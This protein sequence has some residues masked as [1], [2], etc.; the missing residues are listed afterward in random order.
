MEKNWSICWYVRWRY[1]FTCFE[2]VSNE[3]QCFATVMQ[4]AVMQLCV[5]HKCKR[6]LGVGVLGSHVCRL[7]RVWWVC[8]GDT[9][10]LLGIVSAV[11]RMVHYHI[12]S[13]QWWFCSHPFP[14]MKKLVRYDKLCTASLNSSILTAWPTRQA[15]LVKWPLN[16]SIK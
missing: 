6:T 13:G 12:T 3:C 4:S 14:L 5:I 10:L 16:I 11:L 8:G 9:L 15:C 2:V 7:L 1:Y